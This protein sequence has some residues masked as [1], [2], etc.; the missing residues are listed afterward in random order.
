[1]TE[2][3]NIRISMPD[4]YANGHTIISY[5]SQKFQLPAT[6]YA[7]KCSNEDSDISAGDREQL[8]CVAQ[9]QINRFCLGCYRSL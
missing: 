7:W 5:L 9:R 8:Y 1:M 6:L 3:C 2:P 4:S